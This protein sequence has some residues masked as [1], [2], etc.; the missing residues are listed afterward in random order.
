MG[1]WREECY[2]SREEITLKC[3]KMDVFLLSGK[4]ILMSIFDVSLPALS[5]SEI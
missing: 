2:K 3:W 5:A 1:R 4:E